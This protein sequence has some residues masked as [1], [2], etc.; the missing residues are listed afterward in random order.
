MKIFRMFVLTALFMTVGV[1]MC[2]N[3]AQAKSYMIGGQNIH[4][5]ALNSFQYY[6]VKR[7]TPLQFLYANNTTKK[8]ILPKGTIVIGYKLKGSSVEKS[9]MG[10]YLGQLDYNFLNKGRPKHLELLSTSGAMGAS[11]PQDYQ[12]IARPA[13]LPALSLGDFRQIKFSN[14]SSI[15]SKIYSQLRITSNGIAEFSRFKNPDNI[16]ASQRPQFREKIQKATNKGNTR[17]LYF[18]KKIPGLGM[19]KFNKAGKLKYRLT[20]VNQHQ[21]FKVAGSSEDAGSYFYSRYTVGGEKFVTR[22]G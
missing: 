22:I 15:G 21:P 12:R 5:Y 17:Q 14:G 6:K 2:P 19:K 1:L 7:A 11:R 13:Y 20:I 3:K 16:N 10:I 8:R 4:D 18:S 9:T